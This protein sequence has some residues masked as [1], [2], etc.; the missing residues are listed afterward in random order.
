[1]IQRNARQIS[2]SMANAAVVR[3]SWAAYSRTT[4]RSPLGPR[5]RSHRTIHA[6]RFAAGGASTRTARARCVGRW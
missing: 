1:V 3:T 6:L 4:S 5:N 2:H